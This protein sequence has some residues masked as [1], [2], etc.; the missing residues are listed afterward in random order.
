M[1]IPLADVQ[2]LYSQLKEEIDGAIREVLRGGQYILGPN[3]KMLEQEIANYCGTAY[4]IGV[5]SGTDAL[6]LSLLASGIGPGDEVITTPYTF[7]ATAGAVARVG[8]RP[9]FVDIEQDTFNLDLV[10]A[11]KKITR[12]TR[13]I[14]PVHLFGHMSDMENINQLAREYNLLIIEDACQA[15]GSEQRNQKAGS[16]GHLGCFSFFPTKNLGGYGDGGMV[17]TSDPELAKKVQLLRVHGSDK[18]YYHQV[19]GYNSRLDELQAAIIRIKLKHLER[20]NE[21]RRCLAELYGHS[22]ADAG[23][24]LPVEKPFNRHVYN[25]YAIRCPERDKVARD[26]RQ[27]GIAAGVY[28]PLPLHLQEAFSYLDYRPGELPEAERASREVLSLP[29][30]PG[31]M[32]HMVKHIAEVLSAIVSRYA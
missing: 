2:L 26:L 22:L 15:I 1:E 32:E 6:I 31:M 9:V 25:L 20:W 4:G 17:V 29:I 14:I 19:I 28:Y 13:A 21:E 30:Y 11:H 18:K 23:V 12:R 24:T 27:R 8:A 7:F 5:A 10:A 3:V 16:H